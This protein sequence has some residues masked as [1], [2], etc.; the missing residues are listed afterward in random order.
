MSA[1][2]NKDILFKTIRKGD[3]KHL[4]TILQNGFDMS[5]RNEEDKTPLDVAI[6]EQVPNVLE[7]VELLLKA[8]AD[9]S[10]VS[11]S[12][13]LSP[14]LRVQFFRKEA[15]QIV[16]L[17]VNAGVNINYKSR[18]GQTALLKALYIGDLRLIKF[19]LDNGVDVRQTSAAY[20]LA[21]E[22]TIMH[23]ALDINSSLEIIDVLVAYGATNA[24][25][26]YNRA[27]F[28]SHSFNEIGPN[29]LALFST[30]PNNVLHVKNKSIELPWVEAQIQYIQSLPDHE[31]A[32]LGYYTYQGDTLINNYLRGTFDED[33]Y[34]A[35]FRKSAIRSPLFLYFKQA[36][37]SFTLA[38]FKL[39]D[40]FLHMRQNYKKY[41]AQFAEDMQRIAEAAPRPTKPV[42]VFRGIKD[43]SFFLKAL[44]KT[45]SFISVDFQSTSID[46]RAAVSFA[47][48]NDMTGLGMVLEIQL[49]PGTPC[50]YIQS[51]SKFYEEFEIIIP[52]G[53]MFE[54]RGFVNKSHTNKEQIPVAL[55]ESNTKK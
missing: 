31:K 25:A 49:N 2:H 54:S 32:I 1:A 20:N 55:L 50:L 42:K 24:P 30:E 52:P 48:K 47:A 8:G 37:P 23:H 19:M 29:I 53:I 45:N 26:N 40:Y 51:I 38:D 16:N 28:D 12:D 5:I 13:G 11:K 34:F 41:I 10:A 14:L 21:P 9:P 46:P 18:T 6:D 36:H 39:N 43:A 44:K 3:V 7:V 22:K 17:L 15:I 35:E 4:K 33:K 27:P